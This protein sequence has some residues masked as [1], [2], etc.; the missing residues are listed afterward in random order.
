MRRPPKSRSSSLPSLASIADGEDAGAFTSADDNNLP[1]IH[2]GVK[3]PSMRCTRHEHLS[4]RRSF[5]RRFCQSPFV[6]IQP[7]LVINIH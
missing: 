5:Q 2:L 7:P 3:I 1:L 4:Q 6:Q